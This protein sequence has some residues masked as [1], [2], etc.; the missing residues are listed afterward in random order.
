MI[1]PDMRQNA[2]I[3]AATYQTQERSVEG[4]KDDYANYLQN[5]DMMRVVLNKWTTEHRLV[6]LDQTGELA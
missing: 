5:K 3:V 1:G 4:I 6:V 2:D